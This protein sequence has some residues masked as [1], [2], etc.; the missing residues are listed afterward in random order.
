MTRIF[1]PNAYYEEEIRTGKLFPKPLLGRNSIIECAI[2]VL[3]A[4]NRSRTKVITTQT[5]SRDWINYWKNRK[6]SVSDSILPVDSI[7]GNILEKKHS[8]YSSADLEEWGRICRINSDLQLEIDPQLESSSQLLCSKFRQWSWKN[9]NSLEDLSSY[10]IPSKEEAKNVLQKIAQENSENSFWVSKPE[11]GFSGNHKVFPTALIPALQADLEHCILEPWVDR[12]SDHS[13]LFHSINGT[14][15]M[16]AS[17]LLLSDAKGRYVGNWLSSEDESQD[18]IS[19]MK[20]CLVKLS[21]FAPEYSGFGSID[22]FYFKTSQGIQCR[23]VSEINFRWTM[24]RVLLEL[25]QSAKDH[26]KRDLLL[27]VKNIRANPDSYNLLNLW[28][29]ETG[30]KISALSPFS[31]PSEKPYRQVLLWFRIPKQEAENPLGMTKEIQEQAR[32]RFC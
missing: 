31:D 32:L 13:L 16:D 28:E 2:L 15:K 17:T 30:W 27:F 26:S 25:S 22:S 18:Y 5:Q 7:T 11:F 23:R 24:G 4:L 29:K 9:Q 20:E 6:V 21:D 10:M 8:L 3:F 12:V 1:R 14:F 19:E